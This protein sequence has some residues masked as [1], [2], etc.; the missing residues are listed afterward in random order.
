MTVVDRVSES[1]RKQDE[2]DAHLPRMGE[3]DGV[4]APQAPASLE[5]TG[6]NPAILSDLALK[7]CNT[8]PRL[9][10][11]WAAEQLK[12]PHGV[13]ERIFWQLR[14]DQLLEIL[15]QTSGMSYR[16][17]ITQRG[18]EFA[19]RLLEI[20]GYVGPAPVSLEAYTAML[21]WQM[22]QF[23]PVTGEQ[24]RTA[25]SSLVLTEDAV[26]SGDARIFIGAKLVPVRTS[27]VTGKQ[28]SARRC[29]RCL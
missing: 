27:G 3:V 7:L 16:Y 9:T 19:K 21:D 11:E 29:T 23:A 26:G 24:V 2:P 6:V 13:I 1:L 22:T 18:R 28:R 4:L 14:E 15:G 17:S 10:S 20:S 5:D 8:V 25:L 12:L